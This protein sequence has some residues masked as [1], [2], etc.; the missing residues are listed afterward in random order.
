MQFEIIPYSQARP[1]MRVGDMIG[2]RGEHLVQ[3]G[4]IAVRGGFYGLSHLS[5]II[6]DT[7]NE[8]TRRVEVIE[9]VTGG[10][11]R[12]YLSQ[13][14]EAKHGTLYWLPMR[15]TAVQRSTIMEYAAGM[16][17]QG[18]KYDFWS[19]L[20]APF[21]QIVLDTRKFNCSE[22]FWYLQRV[23]GAVGPRYNRDGKEIAPVPGDC[24]V[25]C[26]R[27]LTYQLDMGAGRL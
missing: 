7:Y 8:G 18:I 13:I 14:Y 11:D 3:R 6:R 21:R 22:S 27:L 5:T 2:C 23:A 26:G 25:W 12:A 16:I 10:M 4:I 20:T 9:A 17:E 24:P 15:N 1:N 19:T